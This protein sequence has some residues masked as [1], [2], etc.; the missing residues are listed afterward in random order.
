MKKELHIAAKYNHRVTI[1]LSG[2]EVI[3]GVAGKYPQS[4]IALR[5]ARLKVLRGC[6]MLKLNMC[7]G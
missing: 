3:T 4:L 2:E 6:R 5:Y 7:H 1:R